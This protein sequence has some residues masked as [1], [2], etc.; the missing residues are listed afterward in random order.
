MGKTW[1]SGR[2]SRLLDDIINGKKTIEGRLNKGKF[3]DYA[4]GDYVQLRRDIRATS[5][6][7]VDGDLAEIEVKIVALRHYASFGDM[8]VAEGYK[9]VIPSAASDDEAAEEYN[10]YYTKNDQEQFGV[11][12]IEITFKRHL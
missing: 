7:L 10:K 2:E 12:A 11:I 9:S 8:V 1:V 6:Q 3:A 5:G 4:I